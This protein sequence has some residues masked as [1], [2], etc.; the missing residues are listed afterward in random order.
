MKRCSKCRE[1]KDEAAF[2]KNRFKKD[3]LTPV[4]KAC[5][6]RYYQRG[7]PKA[8]D[9]L[10]RRAHGIEPE[11]F[12]AKAKEQG[13]GCQVCGVVIDANACIDSRERGVIL[14]LLCSRCAR[15]VMLLRGKPGMYARLVEYLGAPRVTIP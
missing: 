14:G 4:C 12:W 5:H 9:D 6:A 13:Y 15:V 3:G 2:S 10:R 8:R 11:V 1:T 7:T